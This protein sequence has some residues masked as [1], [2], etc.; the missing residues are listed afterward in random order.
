MLYS[1][2]GYGRGFHTTAEYHIT[3]D[4][5]SVNH[6]YLDLYFKVPKAYV[7]L[8]DRLRR[9]ITGK[10]NR[11]KLDITINIEK[12]ATPEARVE[13]NRPLISAYLAAIRELQSGYQLPGELNIQSLLSLP[14]LFITM[15]PEEDQEQLTL[16]VS[17]ALEPALTFLLQMR[18]AEGRQLVADLKQ[19]LSL[20]RQYYQSL[21]EAAPLVVT[22][23]REK[24][25]KRLNELAGEVDFDPNRLAQ[26]IAIFADRSDISEELAR[27]ESHLQQF[28][29]TLEI[30]GPAGRKLDFLIQE[31][32]R[33][34]NTIGSKAN[35]LQIAQIVIDFKTEL[36]KLR[37]QIQNLE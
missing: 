8:E 11:G 3:V 27:V 5:K 16:A 29:T 31:L 32:N 35:D 21:T 1:M 6:R 7:F 30:T 20:L 25:T 19:K 18:E 23:Y 22:S 2:T 12:T 26:E 24:L 37:E 9:I 28:L 34:I 10:I 4:I 13:L 36:E 33:E 15:Q 17:Q 14:D